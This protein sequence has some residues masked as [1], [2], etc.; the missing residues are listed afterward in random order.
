MLFIRRENFQQFIQFYPIVSVIIGINTFLF[1]IGFL[2]PDQPVLVQIGGQLYQYPMN[3]LEQWGIGYNAW[4]ASGEYWRLLTPVFL[5]ANLMHFAFNTFALVLFGPALENMFGRL[6]FITLYLLTGIIGNVGTYFLAGMAYGFHLGASGAIYGLLGLYVYMT[7]Y[8]K[9]YIDPQ[10]RQMV[11]T[12]VAVGALYSFMPGINW[13]AHLCG[14]M[15]GALLAP[16]L[17]AGRVQP[18]SPMT[19]T[20]Y[21]PVPGEDVEI[22][23][24]PHRWEKSR[25]R[26]KIIKI[27]IFSLL[28]LFILVGILQALTP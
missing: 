4:V 6:K 12:I 27:V 1:L 5:H 8:H 11:L 20:I 24:D 22:G 21:R 28:G 16:V 19:R 3:I 23:Y 9:E 2:L 7:L 15:G 26:K 17:F 25:K 14:F 13:T 18:Y 10:S